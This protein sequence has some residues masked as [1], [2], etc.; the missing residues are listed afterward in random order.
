VGPLDK[1]YLHTN[2]DKLLQKYWYNLLELV[3]MFNLGVN[4]FI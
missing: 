1:H 2:S 3:F 4:S